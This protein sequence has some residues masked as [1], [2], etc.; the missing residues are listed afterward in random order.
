MR[1]DR[2]VTRPVLVTGGTGTLGRA[3][4]ARLLEVGHPVRI[5][6]RRAAPAERAARA[7]N[8]VPMRDVG[9]L[10]LAL[11]LV[12]TVAAVTLQRLMVGTALC[13]YLVFSVPHFVFHA[14]HVEHFPRG[15]AIAQTIALAI[16]V[17]LPLALLVLNARSGGQRTP[18]KLH[19]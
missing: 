2:P 1:E 9:A 12:A 14:T 13:A 16:G 11:A 15:E 6:S 18:E 4:V 10:N 7:E 17:V 5:A 19:R 8:A 3:V